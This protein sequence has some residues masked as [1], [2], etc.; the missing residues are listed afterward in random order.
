[1]R[2]SLTD[3]DAHDRIS[4]TDDQHYTSHLTASSHVSSPNAALHDESTPTSTF[5]RRHFQDLVNRVRDHGST[6]L[7][8]RVV[9]LLECGARDTEY[10]HRQSLLR[11]NNTVHKRRIRDRGAAIDLKFNRW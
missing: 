10:A 3:G 1:M 4:S 11:L 2:I 7:Y 5:Q 6:A 9:H 8:D